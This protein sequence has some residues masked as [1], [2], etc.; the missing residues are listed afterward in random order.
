MIAN[1]EHNIM[2]LHADIAMLKIKCKDDI[3]HPTVQ[4]GEAASGIK[5]K[6]GTELKAA[7]WGD[8]QG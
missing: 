3:E 8:T 7:G 1:T 4:L 5:E 6:I 2:N